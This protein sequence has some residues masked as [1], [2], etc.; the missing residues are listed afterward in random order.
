MN[1][2]VRV[3]RW[4]LLGDVEE[5]GGEEGIERAWGTLTASTLANEG[6]IGC[7]KEMW[8]A[9]VKIW[10]ST[11]RGR[12][13]SVRSGCLWGFNVSYIDVGGYV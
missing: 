3:G 11:A 12:G 10:G 5:K 7:R 4:V 2:W 13:L 8:K 6:F 1:G 9:E